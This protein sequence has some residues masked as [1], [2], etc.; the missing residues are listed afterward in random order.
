[1]CHKSVRQGCVIFFGFLFSNKTSEKTTATTT[2]IKE[3]N[4]KKG[5]NKKNKNKKKK[6]QNKRVEKSLEQS[7]NILLPTSRDFNNTAEPNKTQERN[8]CNYNISGK[9]RNLSEIIR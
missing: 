8:C 3:K 6:K 4:R 9:V 1:M 2:T 5:S 7:I